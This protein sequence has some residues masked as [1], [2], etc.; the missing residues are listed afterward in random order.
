MLFTYIEFMKGWK[1]YNDYYIRTKQYQNSS[2]TTSKVENEAALQGNLESAEN[3]FYFCLV[4][5]SK[6]DIRERKQ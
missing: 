5:S 1:T 3:I 2:K 6:E 4:F